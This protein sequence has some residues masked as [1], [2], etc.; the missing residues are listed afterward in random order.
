MVGSVGAVGCDAFGKRLRQ[1]AEESG[2]KPLYQEEIAHPTGTCAV[3]LTGRDRSL[4]THLGA[5][6]FFNVSHIHKTEM[7]SAIECAQYFYITGYFVT[8]SLETILE[9]GKHAAQHNKL[10]SMNLSAPFVPQFF[11]EQFGKCLPYCD[12]VFGNDEEILAARTLCGDVAV[13]V[14][15]GFVV[16]MA[17]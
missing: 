11:G 16:W 9:V 15:Q 8:H 17:N 14:E 7:Q 4:V 3:L 6:N 1:C 10:F 13:C 12:I 5:A 2:V